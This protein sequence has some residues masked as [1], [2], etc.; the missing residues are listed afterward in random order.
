M[1]PGSTTTRRKPRKRARNGAVPPDQNRKFPHTAIYGKGYGDCLLGWMRGILGALHAQ[2]ENCEQCNVCR[3]P[4]ESPASCNQVQ[5]TRTSEY[6]CFAAT[7]QCSAPY[8]PFNCCSNPKTCPSSFFHIRRT[9]Q[10][11]PPVTSMSLNR[12]KR[13]WEA[14][15]SGPT[16]RCSRWCMSGCALSEKVFLLGIRTLPKR[17]NTCM[18]RNGDYVE[19]W[20]HCVLFVFSKLRDKKYLKFSFDSPT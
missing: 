2:G 17:W 19:K 3:S 16:K 14:S 18:V 5:T 20:C 4:K 13:W 10:T 12:S 11:S 1:K 15:L 7:W 9:R 8:C 6:R